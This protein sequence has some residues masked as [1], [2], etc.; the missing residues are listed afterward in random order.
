MQDEIVARLAA[1]LG[2]AL[3]AAEARRAARTAN[4]DA[5]D[6]YLQGM[7]WLDKDPRPVNVA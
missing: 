4:P 5:F 7:T 2:T 6:L 1:Q 3:I